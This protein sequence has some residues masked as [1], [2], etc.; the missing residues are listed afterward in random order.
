[1]SAVTD[2]E[3]GP[4]QLIGAIGRGGM[5]TVFAARHLDGDARAAVKVL[6][7]EQSQKPKYRRALRSEVQAL[8][9]LNHPG[10]ASVYDYG[11]LEAEAA[12]ATDGALVEGA[13]W[14]AME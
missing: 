12:E 4:F 6:D 9:R 11:T 10:I 1:M 8:A 2:I 13:P 7:S 5:G 3:C 14:V